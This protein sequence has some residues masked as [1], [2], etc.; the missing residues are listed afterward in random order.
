MLDYNLEDAPSLMTMDDF[1]KEIDI[2]KW[3]SIEKR[4]EN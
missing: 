3:E 4:Y 2:K 1:E